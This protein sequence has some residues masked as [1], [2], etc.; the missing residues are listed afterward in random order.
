MFS[1]FRFPFN[2]YLS[3]HIFSKRLCR[4]L[5]VVPLTLWLFSKKWIISRYISAKYFVWKASCSYKT[6]QAQSTNDIDEVFL[7]VQ[8]FFLTRRKFTEAENQVFQVIFMSWY[9]LL[10]FPAVFTFCSCF[11][12]PLLDC[13]GWTYLP[14]VAHC[15]FQRIFFTKSPRDLMAR[16]ISW[17]YAID[18]AGSEQATFSFHH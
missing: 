6:T 18:L 7:N 11:L 4:P 3:N 16:N 13:R 9:I 8:Q 12:G 15:T 5:C 10:S 17:H 14:E 1:S 2:H